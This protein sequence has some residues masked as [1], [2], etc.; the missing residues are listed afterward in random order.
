MR[1]H[2]HS[3]GKRAPL[4][5]SIDMVLSFI[6]WPL[7]L[8][9]CI[10]FVPAFNTFVKFSS[11]YLNN[12]YIFHFLIPMGAF[13]IFFF[14]AAN[15]QNSM[16]AIAEHEL[17]HALFAL[18]TFHK[19]TG[20]EIEQDKGGHVQL[21]GRGNWLIVLA[22]YFFP[23]FAV[24]ML[25]IGAVYSAFGEPWPAFLLPSYGAMIGYHICAIITQIH[26]KQT[27][28][29][30]AGYLFTFLF[31]PGANL[32]FFGLLFAIAFKQ[33]EGIPLYFKYLWYSTKVFL[34]QIMS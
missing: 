16:L 32:I 9:L 7:A 15:L 31:L 11:E 23:T 34:E 22:P 13:C 28:F 3:S 8:A 30:E 26:P 19:I 24:I 17:T 27:D 20:M 1:H 6:K 5:N 25:L 29:N 2:N 18:L 12:Y 33:W 21:I 10:F 14:I 4:H